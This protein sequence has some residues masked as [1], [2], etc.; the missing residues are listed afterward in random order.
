MIELI[1]GQKAPEQY[2]AVFDHCC[3]EIAR[4]AVAVTEIMAEYGS[5]DGLRIVTNGI[6]VTVRKNA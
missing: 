6:I 3:Q 1:N 5:R 2:Q 4:H